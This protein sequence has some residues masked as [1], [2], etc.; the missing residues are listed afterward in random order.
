[1]QRLLTGLQIGLSAE[2]NKQHNDIIDDILGIAK[3]LDTN[4]DFLK[5]MDVI[6]YGAIAH[7]DRHDISYPKNTFS[8]NLTFEVADSTNIFNAIQQSKW[9]SLATYKSVHELRLLDYIYASTMVQTS[10][11]RTRLKLKGYPLLAYQPYTFDDFQVVSEIH[12]D[13]TGSDFHSIPTYNPLLS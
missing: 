5:G 6:G 8:L 2:S 13:Y 12:E 11:H 4:G 3:M 10:K 1:M 7:G 9:R